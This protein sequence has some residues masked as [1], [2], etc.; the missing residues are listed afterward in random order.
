MAALN[1]LINQVEDKALRDRLMQEA[2]RLT[3]QKKFG[4]VFEEHIPE[5]TPLY[6]IGIK[7]GSIV[8]KKTGAINDVYRGT[9]LGGDAAVCL[10]L[11][12]GESETVVL[13][14][15]VPVAQFGEPIYPALQPIAAVENAP[16]SDLWHNL[17]EADNYHALQLLE[18][19]YPKQVDCI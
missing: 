14:E 10:R 15:L 2:A 1:D 17:I 12:S 7:R 3:K 8:A 6:G 5:C 9:E 4:L 18:Y 16:D 13:P 19:L 11:A